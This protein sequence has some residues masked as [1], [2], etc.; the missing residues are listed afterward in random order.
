[1][2]TKLSLIEI[3]IN[4]NIEARSTNLGGNQKNICGRISQ[5]SVLYV[6]FIIFIRYLNKDIL[7]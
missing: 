1:M 5:S 7:R 4:K 6:V 3:L 2:H